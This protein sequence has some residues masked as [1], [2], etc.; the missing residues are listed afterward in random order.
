MHKLSS[1]EI[2][3]LAQSK[4]YEEFL[5]NKDLM[6]FC[7]KKFC[8][9]HAV[10]ILQ[11]MAAQQHDSKLACKIVEEGKHIKIGDTLWYSLFDWTFKFNGQQYIKNNLNDI[12]KSIKLWFAP[13]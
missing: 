5:V 9:K 3:K 12:L 2:L 8:Q 4:T 1:D 6:G 11:T 13:T 10:E 7:K